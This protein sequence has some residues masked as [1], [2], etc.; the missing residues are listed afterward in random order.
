MPFPL[1]ARCEHGPSDRRHCFTCLFID[2]RAVA[3]DEPLIREK[4]DRECTHEDG[5]ICF[6]F[7]SS[8]CPPRR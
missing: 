7:V 8:G 6:A 5:C 1:A 4:E 3:R 2:L